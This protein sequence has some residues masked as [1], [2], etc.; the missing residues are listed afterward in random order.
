MRY[1]AKK[2]EHTEMYFIRDTESTAKFPANLVRGKNHV[3]FSYKKLKDCEKRL[4]ILNREDQ[5][6][7]TG[8]RE[9]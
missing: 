3:L 9:D 6:A 2:A 7:R 1:V 4:E 5:L 8:V